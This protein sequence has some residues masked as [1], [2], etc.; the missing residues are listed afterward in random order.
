MDLKANV[1]WECGTSM[2]IIILFASFEINPGMND[3]FKR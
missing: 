1:Q 3:F 2:N